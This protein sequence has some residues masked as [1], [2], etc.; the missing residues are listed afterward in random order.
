MMLEG[1]CVMIV[2]MRM[3]MEV[4]EEPNLV[5]VNVNDGEYVI[6]NVVYGIGETIQIKTDYTIYTVGVIACFAGKRGKWY[7]FYSG[8]KA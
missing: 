4:Q 1:R 8:C 2:W 3:P 7:G 5:E 6:S